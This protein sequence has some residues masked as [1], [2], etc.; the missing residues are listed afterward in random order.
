MNS[1]IKPQDHRYTSHR[2][3]ENHQIFPPQSQQ[4]EK[5]KKTKES[6]VITIIIKKKPL[7]KRLLL[8]NQFG[9]TSFETRLPT[10]HITYPAALTEVVG[11]Y[12]RDP[13]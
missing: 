2:I 5:K 12:E 8:H 10:D 6:Q 7:T 3:S 4:K 9:F 13:E 11:I 1:I